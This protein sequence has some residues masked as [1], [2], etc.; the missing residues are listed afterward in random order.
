MNE[1]RGIC[2][3]FREEREEQRKAHKAG[4][5]RGADHEE[6]PQGT[7]PQW[8]QKPGTGFSSHRN[9]RQVVPTASCKE[10][11]HHVSRPT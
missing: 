5:C 3:Y 11:R 8:V 7:K 6:K 9:T 2:C 4:S 10:P 1:N